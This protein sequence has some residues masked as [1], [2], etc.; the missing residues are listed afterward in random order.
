[1]ALKK[2]FAKGRK[3]Y[4][5]IEWAIEYFYPS[6]ARQINGPALPEIEAEEHIVIEPG[7]F[8]VME[9]LLFAE[10]DSS[11][12]Q[13]LIRESGKLKSILVRTKQLWVV[14]AWR[15][16][17]VFDAIRQ[18]L[19]RIITLGIAGFDTPISLTGIEEVSIAVR[20]DRKS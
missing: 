1:M 18:E 12:M 17:Q 11:Q 13:A 14:H 15:N 16:D 20:S 9:E 2:S 19:Y 5:K 3:W 8:Q 4:K 7:G 10:Q 6:T